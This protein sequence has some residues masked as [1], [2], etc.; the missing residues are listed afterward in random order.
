MC[1][2]VGSLFSS[3]QSPALAGRLHAALDS[4]AH[5]GPDGHGELVL[6][7][8]VLGHAR[9]SI[10]DLS[11]AASQP[12]QSAD[13]QVT[14]V[15][16]GEIYNYRELYQ[17]HLRD[18]AG[19]N[20]HSDTS[21]LL[22]MYVR[23]G[24]AMLPHLNGMF[25]FVVWDARSR[26]VFMARDRFGEKPLYYAGDEQQLVFGSECRALQA[27]QPGQLEEIDSTALGAYLHL[28]SVHAPRTIFRRIRALPPGHCASVAFGRW[29]DVRPRR[30]WRVG[31]TVNRDEVARMS[32][33]EARAETSRLLTQAL[34]SRLVSDV[35]VGLFLSGGIDSGSICSLART[36]GHAGMSGVFVDFSETGFSELP[37]ARLTAERFGIDMHRIEI[38]PAEFLGSLS[39]FFSASDQPT[40]DGFNTYIVAQAAARVGGKVWLSG[41]GGD[42][43]FGGYPLFDR[44]GRL[45]RLS[46][47]MQ[48]FTPPGLLDRLARIDRM[49]MRLRRALALGR[50][51][52]NASRAF[53]AA[54]APLPLAVAGGLMAQ[55]RR[56]LDSAYI[57]E[58]LAA[59]V[60]DAGD[61]FQLASAFETQLYMG[62]QLLRDMDNFS[63]A[64]SLELRAPFLDHRLYDF[65]YQ[66]PAH[67]KVGGPG[68]KPLLAGSLPGALPDEVRYA[69]KRGFTFPLEIW[70][71]REFDDAF[72][73]VCTDPRLA[74]LLDIQAVKRLWHGY[75]ANQVHWSVVWIPFALGR[76]LMARP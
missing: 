23:Y 26:T 74:D 71:K 32:L 33:A 1:G 62:G 51:G 3:P 72:Q 10:I 43:L 41:V 70:M 31:A 37:T 11:D 50:P 76:W 57:D 52:A 19:V 54:R 44:M 61:D 53:Q 25:S 46:T 2:Y 48:R 21:V 24:E 55:Q 59:A 38:A 13:G 42:E 4:I 7:H 8:A 17:A 40:A 67:L 60:P 29:T 49:P 27:L 30:Y 14:L 64:H 45:R 16:N 75:R 9:L 36:V 66:L 5:R 6:P 39:S 20:P 68:K 35:P 34:S 47:A 73:Q 65:V 63:M 22:G 69:P 58:L 15:F 18:Q 56:P 12:M 28:G